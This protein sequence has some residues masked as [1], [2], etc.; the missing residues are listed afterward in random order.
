MKGSQKI[1]KV[2]LPVSGYNEIILFGLV[3]TDPHYKIALKLNRKIGVNLKSAPPVEISDAPGKDLIFTL[4]S[5]T[6]SL[7]D[8]SL[9]FLSNRSGADFLLRKLGNIDYLLEIYDPSKVCFSLD[10]IAKLRE[11]DTVTAVFKIDLNTI[12]DKN[13]KF[14]FALLN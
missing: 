10:L 12:K 8:V 13:L 9:H 11:I 6:T 2:Q 4:F 7:H 14:L 1:K 5:D 3:C